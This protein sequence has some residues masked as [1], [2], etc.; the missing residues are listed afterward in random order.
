ML[1]TLICV[2][3]GSIL[4]C[5]SCTND[6]KTNEFDELELQT[7]SHYFD[8]FEQE[9][10]KRGVVVDLSQIEGQIVDLNHGHGV[11]GKCRYNPQSPN[12]VLIDKSFWDEANVYLKEQ[13]VFHELG[14]CYLHKTHNDTQ[15]ADG[16]CQSIMRSGISGCADRYNQATR[17]LYLDELFSTDGN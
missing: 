8:L 17:E 5:T 1:R 2:G 15:H 9:A 7:L 11:A 13:V 4:L 16:T 3:I 14:H 6:A 12:Q 10:A